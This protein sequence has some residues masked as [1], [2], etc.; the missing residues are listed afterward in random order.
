MEGPAGGGETGP[1]QR[2]NWKRNS[3]TAGSG[4]RQLGTNKGNRGGTGHI[5][6]FRHLDGGWGAKG[7][8]ACAQQPLKRDA[9]GTKIPDDRWAGRRGRIKRM[10]ESNT[11]S[12][13][14]PF[15]IPCQNRS[16]RKAKRIASNGSDPYDIEYSLAS[17][18]PSP[19]PCDQ[20]DHFEYRR[21]GF[22]GI[23]PWSGSSPG[24]TKTAE[25]TSVRGCTA[26]SRT[27]R[28][29]R[30]LHPV[31]FPTSPTTSHSSSSTDGGKELS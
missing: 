6:R 4:R 8:A 1:A 22:L 3:R 29:F 28:T 5:T 30:P 26:R 16:G 12:P 10:P 17:R 2:T 7:N 24:T 21:G 19:P 9:R 18:P 13:S 15:L 27:L 23:C 25:A 31:W 14:S 20:E 11:P